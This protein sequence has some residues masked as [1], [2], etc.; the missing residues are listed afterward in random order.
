MRRGL[1]AILA[2]TLSLAPGAAENITVT[3]G[4]SGGAPTGAAGG[5]LSGTYPNPGVAKI[6]GVTPGT[7]VAAALG[8][9]I[10]AAGA[11][12]TF[13]GAGGTP[14]SL[15][16][17]NA[18]GLPVST[19]VSGLG[20]GVAAALGNTAGGAGG[21]A[22]VSAANVASVSNSDGTLT[23]SP[24]TGAVVASIALAHANTW[25]GNQTISGA[26]F[27]LS[28][29]ISAAAWTTAG[30][31]YANV[32]GTLTDTTSSGTVAAAY[33]DVFGG[34]TIAASSAVTFTNYT[35]LYVKAPVAGTNATFT[36]AYALGAD[37]LSLIGGT[38]AGGAQVLNITATQP[39]V[40]GTGQNAII[41]TVTGAGNASN[42][43]RA[44]QINYNA[45]YTGSSLTTAG[46]INNSNAGTGSTLVP[47]SGN[48]TVVGNLAQSSTSSGTTTGLNIGT[49]GVASNGN[50]NAGLLGIA[51][52]AKNSA[53]NIGVVGSAINTGTSPVQIG[54]WF[55]LNQTTTPTVS[56]ALIADNGS[57]SN[58]VAL[59]R[60]A[61]VTCATV[62]LS[63][64]IDT[65]GRITSGSTTLAAG[66]AGDL[67]QIKE[68]DAAAAPGAGYA[69]LK[70]VAGTNSGSCKL[71]GYAGTSATPVTIVDNIGGGC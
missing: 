44:F 2:F 46:S 19:G 20:S 4:G 8:N 71:I 5:D 47:A 62:D 23:I 50:L 29:N 64:N 68:T 32:A 39:A 24:T 69:V 21:F 25:T 70:W 63:G 9:N 17:T 18:T 66:Q 49:N 41:I 40:P 28:G 59:F 7:G 56:A 13:N 55:S 52:I 45:G 30:V 65:S 34:N 6:A 43:N 22:L 15:T 57:Q 1:A 51:Q 26:A 61:G 36:S 42:I 11:P 31:R 33:S 10:G 60:C 58:P 27:A 67:G 38:L 14:S 16:L 53:T 37:S 48:V 3:P 54:G 12:V 35:S